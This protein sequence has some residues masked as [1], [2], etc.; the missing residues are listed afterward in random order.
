MLASDVLDLIDI[1]FAIRV[2]GIDG[3]GLGPVGLSVGFVCV[4]LWLTR[5]ARRAPNFDL[6]I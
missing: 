3:F 5:G 4:S 1:G 6:V 2:F